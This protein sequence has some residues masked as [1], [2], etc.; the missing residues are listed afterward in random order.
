M[1]RVFFFY[2]FRSCLSKQLRIPNQAGQKTLYFLQRKPSLEWP[3]IRSV[4]CD[5]PLARRT[6]ALLT[7]EFTKSPGN[8]GILM[9]E[10]TKKNSNL[11]HFDR[12]CLKNPP[13]ISSVLTVWCTRYRITAALSLSGSLFL[14]PE[15]G[16]LT[17]HVIQKKISY[18]PPPPRRNYFINYS[19]RIILCNGRGPHYRNFM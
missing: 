13:R 6:T 16:M 8:S 11:Q 17:V 15:T 18:P 3:P 10:F 9:V 1:H 14:I 2:R 12:A 5:G 7:V 4:C 19:L